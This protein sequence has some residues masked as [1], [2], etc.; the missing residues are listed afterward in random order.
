VRHDPGLE[1]LVADGDGG[2]DE[3]E[4]DPSRASPPARSVFRRE[5]AVGV[6]RVR[7]DRVQRIAS[8]VFR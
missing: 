4:R 2:G 5:A 8:L 7:F 3:S 1:E 6:C